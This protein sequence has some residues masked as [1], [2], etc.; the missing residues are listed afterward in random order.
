MLKKLLSYLKKSTNSIVI[1]YKA[2][3]RLIGVL[4]ILLPLICIIGGCW[5]GKDVVQ[6]SISMYYYTNMRDFL[7]GLLFVV[8]LF[9]LTYKGTKMIDLLVTSITGIAGLGVAVFPCFNELLIDQRVGIFQLYPATSNVFHLTFA[10]TF[11]FLLA[12]N[13]IFLFTRKQ[14]VETSEKIT[15]NGIY[16]GCGVTILICLLVMVLCMILMTPD[17]RYN[18]KIILILESISLLAFGISWLVKGQTLF[19]DKIK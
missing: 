1:S 15:R 5:F 6:Q 11:F 2:L 18:T 12:I 7:V 9:L 13:S 19:V 10:V 3:R 4:G 16:I 17:Q 14:Q 8:S